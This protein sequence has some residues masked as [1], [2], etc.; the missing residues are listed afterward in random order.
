[1]RLTRMKGHAKGQKGRVFDNESQLV[2]G[3]ISR[4]IRKSPQVIILQYIFLSQFSSEYGEIQGNGRSINN[5][6]SVLSPEGT[7]A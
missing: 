3:I 2:S 5:Y 4:G 7:G 1:M 6:A